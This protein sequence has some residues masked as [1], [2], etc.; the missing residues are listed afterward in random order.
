MKD[1]NAQKE[2]I[3]SGGRGDISPAVAKRIRGIEHSNEFLITYLQFG[4]IVMMSVFYALAPKG[5]TPTQALFQP[6]PIALAIWFVLLLIRLAVCRR[7][8]MHGN[9][10]YLF[11]F[12]DIFLLLGVIFSFHLQYG[13][14][15]ALSLKA[16]TYIFLV[17]LV[18]LRSLRFNLRYIIVACLFA[19]FG[20]GALVIYASIT[21]EITNNYY[22]Y[23]SRNVLLVGAE[24]EKI[25]G[26]AAITAVMA[27]SVYKSRSILIYSHQQNQAV[28]SLSRF[29]SSEVAQRVSG[30]NAED[31]RPGAG[32]ER[33]GVVIDIDIRGFTTFSSQNSVATVMQTLSDYQAR[34]VPV[35]SSA[36]GSIDKFLGDGILVHFGVVDDNADYAARAF[37]CME[38]IITTFIAWNR[39]RAQQT[40]PPINYGI[41]M[42]CGKVLFGTVGDTSRMEFTVIGTAVNNSAKY[43]KATKMLK[44][45][46]VS[47]LECY[48][49]ALQQGY[50][51][52]IQIFLS[53]NR[54]IPGISVPKNVVSAVDPEHYPPPG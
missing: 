22:E 29:F 24:V 51:P 49:L 45:N 17:L 21:S 5:F 46:F 8:L 53:K 32:E 7:D 28:Q 19:I 1:K 16:P 2:K 41:G 27:I 15:P 50:S 54:T 10:V 36:G 14:V 30:G 18:V 25:I 12:L 43:E 26:L 37:R 38:Q 6:V 34:L 44:A 35:I 9:A 40:L 33:N 13:T 42:E 47:S 52:D 4:F 3:Q 11:T 39:E 31:L 48:K 23:V 20:W